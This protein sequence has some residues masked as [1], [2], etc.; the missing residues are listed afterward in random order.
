MKKYKLLGVFLSF[1]LIAGVAQA[2]NENVGTSTSKGAETSSAHRSNVANVVEGL[3]A[4][5]G[6]DVNIGEDLRAVAQEQE[7]VAVRTAEA[8]KKVETRSGFKTFLIG[9]DYK[10]LGAI[11]SE[12]ASTT[13]NIN[14]LVK[15]RERATDATVQAELDA[16]IA[17]LQKTNT[18]V[19]AFVK[20]NESKFSLFGWFVKLF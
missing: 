6:K 4:T 15:A 5:A 2:Q 9:T 7:Q 13:N 19:E 12:L 18:D 17:L 3:R 1:L 11:R 20:S 10:N 16:E 14:R 8:I